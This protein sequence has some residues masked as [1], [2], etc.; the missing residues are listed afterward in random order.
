MSGVVGH[1]GVVAE[2]QRRPIRRRRPF[3]GLQWALIAVAVLVMAVLIVLGRL[4]WAGLAGIVTGLV[5]LSVVSAEMRG[6]RR[7]NRAGR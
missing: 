5:I 4:S 6:R 7:K 1:A 2:E 3:T